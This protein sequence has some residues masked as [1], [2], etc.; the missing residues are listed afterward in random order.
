[1]AHNF[2]MFS[3]TLGTVFFTIAII[4]SHRIW[5]MIPPKLLT[6]WVTVNILIWFFLAGYILLMVMEGA[7]YSFYPKYL[8]GSVF[9]AGAFFVFIVINISK[10]T[11]GQFDKDKRTLTAMH[12]QLRRA[13]ESTIEGWGRALELRD[14]ET[15]G[16]TKR[17]CEMTLLLARKFSLSDA[18]RYYMKLGCLLHDIGKMGIPDNILKKQGPLSA[19]EKLIIEKHPEFA[20]E[21]LGPIEFLAPALD[22]PYCHHEKWDGSGY[23]RGLRGHEIPLAARIFAVVDVWDDLVSDRHY[24][25]GWTIDKVCE[26]IIAEAGSHFDPQVV[27]KFLELELCA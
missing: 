26:H 24:H 20:K 16:H 15:E 22:I 13:Y 1:M 5:P 21:L 17:V 3:L 9:L 7:D 18:E 14:K 2:L 4:A 6:K 12:E 8:D 10:I 11:I 19:A 27:A 25:K 23:P